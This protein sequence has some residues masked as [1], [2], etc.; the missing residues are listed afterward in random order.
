GKERGYTLVEMLIVVGLLGLI[1]AIAV[2]ANTGNDEL[3][4]DRATAEVAS[5]FRFARSEAIRTGDGH[6]LTVSQSTQE[7]TVKKYD[8]TIVPIA[9]LG[10]LTNPISKQPYD[11]N[12]NTGSGTEGVTISN[13][14][15]VFNYGSEGRRRSLIFEENG[16][17]IWIVGSDP[18]RHLLVDGIVELT[19]G[20]QQRRVEVSAMTGRVTIQ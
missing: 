18:T 9:T 13:S 8:I 15:D 1:A 3:K 20:N 2:P 11:F 17:P 10:T 14:S 16:V 5:A 7:V 6:G 19:Y 4:L 12:V